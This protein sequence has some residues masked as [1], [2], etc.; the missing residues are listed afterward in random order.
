MDIKHVGDLSEADTLSYLELAGVTDP[1]LQDR[2]CEDARVARDQIHP[3]SLG[4][5]ADLALAAAREGRA[6]SAADLALDPS[7]GDRRRMVANRLLRYVN[8]GTRY[9]VH[10]IAASRSFDF[11]VYSFLGQVLG[12]PTSP[13]EFE[14]LVAFSFVQRDE[15]GRYRIHELVRRFGPEEDPE[16]VPRV[17]EALA[18]YYQIR[19][20][21]EAAELIAE[22][23]YHIAYL[24]W[25]SGFA[26][27]FAAFQDAYLGSRFSV[28]EAL[29]GIRHELPIEM[30]GA[31]GLL[32]TSEGQYLQR[33]SR[34]EEARSR[35]LEAIAAFDQAIL[36]DPGEPEDLNNKGNALT[37]LSEVELATSNRLAAKE[38]LADATLAFD[39]AITG[40]ALN[41]TY[42]SNKAKALTTLGSIQL[43]EGDLPA[44]E[45]S[46]RAA[47]HGIRFALE[48]LPEEAPLLNNLGLAITGLANVQVMYGNYALAEQLYRRAIH[49]FDEALSR[50]S[51]IALI[52]SNKGHA[53]HH[54]AKTYLLQRRRRSA[55][56]CYR[57]A[58]SATNDALQL[59]P[60]YPLGLYNKALYCEELGGWLMR[61]WSTR[62][63]QE[64]QRLVHVGIR[65]AMRASALAPDDGRYS[66]VEQR[67]R[68]LQ[69]LLEDY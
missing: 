22:A 2:L 5:G 43:D 59:A 30:P 23:I 60:D 33:L 44:A 58:I 24:D 12:F 7:A 64:A 37:L 15:Q 56:L 13:S 25:R 63:K 29:L 8:T 27:W 52:H 17:H 62:A 50:I 66:A 45:S 20:A 9:A 49:A 40:D 14:T 18:I 69:N 35:F 34:F 65:A 36:D 26:A 39:G 21:V 51:T 54:L 4:L 19:A 16:F 11:S 48:S 1:A 53:L 6:L 68:H 31:T 3:L 47:E 32:L 42:V 28:C 10:A 41:V 61:R 57:S 46:Y 67:L 55:A 38:H